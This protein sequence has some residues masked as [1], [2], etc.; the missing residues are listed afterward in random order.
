MTKQSHTQKLKQP[1][2]TPLNFLTVVFIVG[3]CYSHSQLSSNNLEITR[4]R[5]EQ[6][7][8]QIL[9]KV[10]KHRKCEK[11]EKDQTLLANSD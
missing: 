7:E 9:H 6:L 2:S 4:S 8:N 1:V 10:I 3:L 11:D 5:K